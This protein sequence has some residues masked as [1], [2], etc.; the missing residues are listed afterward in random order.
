MKINADFDQRVLL[1]ADQIEWMASPMPGVS[2]RPLDRIGDEVARATTIVRFDPGS[3][4]SPHTHGG[5]EEFIVLEGV[6]QDELGDILGESSD[7]L[8]QFVAD[9]VAVERTLA[10]ERTRSEIGKL[11]S[12]MAKSLRLYRENV[13]DIDKF[14]ELHQPMESR[15]SQRYSGLHDRCY[16]D[17]LSD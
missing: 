14:G 8:S 15:L 1:H 12:E 17:S 2:R 7:L 9:P 5:G 10:L 11:E 6:F 4:F 3:D 13:I 16:A